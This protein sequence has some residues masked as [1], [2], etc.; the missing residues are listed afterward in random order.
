MTFNEHVSESRL[1]CS[2]I[3]GIQPM[4]FVLMTIPWDICDGYKEVALI[5]YEID[6][7]DFHN[8]NMIT[9]ISISKVQQSA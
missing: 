5:E 7:D 3:T 6:S 2:N 8:S 9:R 1:I 4:V